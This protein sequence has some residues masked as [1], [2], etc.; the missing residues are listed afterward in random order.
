MATT[1][2]LDL[3][4]NQGNDLVIGLI[5]ESIKTQ[6]EFRL[7]PA[8]T[9]SGT[10][11]KTV[12]RKSLPTAQFRN[13]NEGVT[14]TKSEYEQK[15]VETFIVDLQIACDKAI[16]DAWEGGRE[17]YFAR[18]ALGVMESAMRLVG[19]QV[20][21]GVSNDA[22]GFPGLKAIVDSSMEVDAGGS[23]AKTSVWAVKYGLQDVQFQFGNNTSLELLPE[24]R[25]ETVLD[26]N[27]K[28]YT[29]YVNNLTGWIGLQVVNKNSIARIKNVGTDSGKGMTDSLAHDLLDSF[30]SGVVP[31]AIFM[32]RRS[33]TQLRK[34]RTATNPSGQPPS[35][36]TD[37]DGVPIIVTDSI[38]NAE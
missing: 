4:K 9:I 28:P 20:Y 18:E 23:T 21:Y 37:I 33:R 3:A 31:D 11:Y 15:T 6:P 24:W 14:R 30:P 27:N 8:R 26:S 38:T 10:S 2:L 25:I 32:S 16:A 12:I 35:M 36:P 17:T 13:A 7:F 1:T 29:A 5:E 22:K 34:S 19:S